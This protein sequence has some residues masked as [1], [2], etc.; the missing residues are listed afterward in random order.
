MTVVFPRVLSALGI[1]Y[2]NSV[3]GLRSLAR[4]GL[5][6]FALLWTAITFYA[7]F[8]EYLHYKAMVEQ[9]RVKRGAIHCFTPPARNDPPAR[10][11]SPG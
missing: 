3:S 7:T 5:L 6:A 9:H 1:P 10:G 2:L 8:S 11:R 4:Y